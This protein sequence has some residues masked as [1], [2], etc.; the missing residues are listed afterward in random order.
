[1]KAN[2]ILILILIFSLSGITSCSGRKELP[3]GQK[4]GQ[5]SDKGYLIFINADTPK[6]TTLYSV[7]G[8]GKNKK[9]IYDK[10]PYGAAASGGMIAFLAIENGKQNMY[11]INADGKGLTPVMQNTDIKS[12]SISWSQDG[13][14]LVFVGKEPTDLNYQVYYVEK[15]SDRTPVRVTNDSNL[16]ES[17]RFSTD[18]KFIIYS[19]G[20][21]NNF[22]IYRVDI[23]NSKIVNLSGSITND[24]SPVASPDGMKILLLSD[25][26]SK[27]KYNLYSMGIDGGSRM[28][29]TTG[30]NIVPDSMKIS[31]NSSMISFTVLSDSGRKSV[32]IMDMNKSTVMI[33]TDAYMSAWS[34]DGKILYFTSS[35][36]QYRK[37]ME[38]EISGKSIKDTFKMQYKPGEDSTGIKFLH[39]TD[40]LK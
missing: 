25:E 38:Y 33:S 10:N 8:D 32:E 35:D 3:G 30:R 21:D 1:M 2:R 12:G 20:T 11:T 34:G 31:P 22:H 5:K 17:P 6:K 28:Q 13:G 4:E 14:K 26:K 15:G 27:G 16:K 19:G 18:G 36:P 37:I 9:K 7:E 23:G 40:K 39:F 24:I 29:L